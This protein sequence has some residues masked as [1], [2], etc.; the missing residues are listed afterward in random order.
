MYVFGG[1]VNER[2]TH[3]LWSFDTQGLNWSLLPEKGT[4]GDSP[5]PVAG[6]TATL[7]GSKMIV[8]FGY[9]PQGNYTN[10]VQEYD[11]GKR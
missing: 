9:G 3:E 7:V 4:Q 10:K 2:A 11:L 1:R 6:H 8:L 5:V